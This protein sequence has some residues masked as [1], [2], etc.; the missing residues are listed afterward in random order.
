M[1]NHPIVTL[2]QKI[3]SH[4]PKELLKYFSASKKQRLGK[5]YLLI[6]SAKNEEQRS[7]A[8]LFKKIFGKSYSD[9]NDYLWRNE[10]RLLKEELEQFLLQKEHYFLVQNNSTYKNWL[11]IHAFD[12][13][14]FI[15]GMDEKH[16]TLLKE[17]DDFAS[18][19][20]VLDACMLQLQNLHY[21][22]TDLTKRLNQYPTLLGEA[23]NIFI[24]LVSAYNAKLNNYK[25]HYNWIAYNHQNEYREELFF[26]EQHFILTNNPIS[27]FF[28]SY[29]L[30]F[31]TS[32]DTD[33]FEAQLK[34]LNNAIE[35]IEPLYAKNKL[36]HEN[37]F[38][39]LMSKGRELSA[40]GYFL[41]AHETLSKIKE[42]A[43]KLNIHNKTIFYVNYIT[44]LVKCKF[45]KEALHTLENEFSTE[46]TLYKNM[47]LQNRLLC[48]LF[49]RNTEQ[50]E[51]YIS[52]DLDAAPFPQNYMLKVIKSA[53]FYLIKDYETA[54]NII[55]S[56]LNAKYASDTMQ[57]YQPI[58]NTYK[59]LYT[60]ALKNDALKR[61]SEKDI[62]QLENSITE[63]ESN[64]PLEFQKVSVYLWLKEEIQKLNNKK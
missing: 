48:Y 39:V 8:L 53:Y 3:E 18:Y 11:L 33:A 55:N 17:K 30:S 37:R 14:K 24:D 20:F 25:A 52:Y 56:L 43:D 29:S 32:A 19:A 51:K 15:E 50:L 6:N 13:L 58:S 22:I 62:N 5:L 44:N 45:Y 16:E 1:E 38:L 49:L 64:S 7:K 21:K 4:Y 27:N 23:K 10:I 59:K 28:N 2:I 40:N 57:Y 12:K 61:Y 42:D 54:L 34:H 36:L 46:N 9:K 63:F 60:I 31:S 47:L 35:I 26:D 41:E